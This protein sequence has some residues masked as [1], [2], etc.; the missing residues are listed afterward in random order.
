MVPLCRRKAGYAQIWTLVYFSSRKWDR[1]EN[2]T[3][4]KVGPFCR[5]SHFVEGKQATVGG[6][7]STSLLESGTVVKMGLL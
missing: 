3:T 5:W 6:A 2:G 7:L 4:L 1:G